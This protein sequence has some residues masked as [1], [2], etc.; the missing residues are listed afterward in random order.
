MVFLEL[1]LWQGLFAS[2][3]PSRCARHIQIE[4]LRKVPHHIGEHRVLGDGQP[5]PG[6]CPSGV[7]ELGEW[8][9]RF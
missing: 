9:R 6:T 7:G 8:K 1:L 4:E 2:A 5:V 3:D